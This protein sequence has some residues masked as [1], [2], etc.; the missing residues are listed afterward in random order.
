MQSET[1][2]SGRADAVGV[3]TQGVGMERIKE[4]VDYREP[5]PWR[6]L[7]RA[8][9]VLA[10]VLGLYW[11]TGDAACVAVPGDRKDGRRIPIRRTGRPVGRYL[12]V[13]RCVFR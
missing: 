11:L 5:D 7:L 13:E 9:I 10:A 6:S 1:H 2:D 8:G 3:E 12:E 4:T